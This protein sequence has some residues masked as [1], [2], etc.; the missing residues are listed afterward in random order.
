MYNDI[1]DVEKSIGLARAQGLEILLDFHYSDN[2]ADPGNQEIP[3]AWLDITDINVLGDSVYNY[4][5]KTLNYLKSKGLQPDLVQIGNETNCGML[6]T[7]APT[8]FPS[9]NVCTGSW[10]RMGL[11]VNRAIEAIRD[12]SEGSSIDTRVVLHVADPKNV[13]W[14]FD[15]MKTQANVTDFDVVGFSYYPLW[16]TTVSLS[17]ISNQVQYFKNR[18]DKEVVILETAYP[19]TTAADDSYTNLFGSQTPLV[20]YPFTVKGQGDFMIR[21]AQEVMD[22]GGRGVVYWEPAWIT[23]DMKDQW[24]TGSAWENATFFDF[25]GN[26]IESIGFMTH[27]YK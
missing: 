1:K 11:V 12:I 2:W 3:A 8:G 4:T 7:D 9:C 23:S 10:S 18:Y 20:G 27:E 25:E 14:W 15:N 5:Y 6:Y 19:W 22:G 13:E 21:L 24:G 16:H 17:N 26:T